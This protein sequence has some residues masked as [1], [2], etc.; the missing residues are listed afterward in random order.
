MYIMLGEGFSYFPWTTAKRRAWGAW[1]DGTVKGVVPPENS[2]G[3][4]IKATSVRERQSAELRV[5]L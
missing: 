3:R 2:H 5:L 4:W 1:R